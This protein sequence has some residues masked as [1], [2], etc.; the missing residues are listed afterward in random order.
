MK[1]SPRNLLPSAF[2][3]VEVCLALG[4]LAFGLVALLGLYPVGLESV[5]SSKEKVVH[6]EIIKSVTSE[7]AGMRF[8]QLGGMNGKAYHF[9]EEG[10]L[11]PAGNAKALYLASIQTV[12]TNT[13]V[14][15]DNG[16]RALGECRTLQVQITK[17][18]QPSTRTYNFVVAN[19]GL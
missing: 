5:R 12:Q 9:S 10:I 8:D 4:V 11:V 18:P 14:P 2:S 1:T 15:A 6:A 19:H 16:S 13:Q 7:F 3:L 17:P